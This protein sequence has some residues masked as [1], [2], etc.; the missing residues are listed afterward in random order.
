MGLHVHFSAIIYIAVI[1]C[2][3]AKVGAIPRG[4]SSDEYCASC[5]TVAKHLDR[6]VQNPNRKH[7]ETQI[8]LSLNHICD[9][10][11]YQDAQD[12]AILIEEACRYMIDHHREDIED[13]LLKYYRNKIENGKSASHLH[14]VQNV[15]G[16]IGA[17]RD[18]PKMKPE[19]DDHKHG[20]I[21][22]DEETE[23]VKIIP[24][25]KVKI[26]G[27]RKN[28]SATPAK[29]LHTVRKLHDEL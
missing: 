29:L 19:A 17:C 18:R 8:A 9:S 1:I 12:H 21:Y 5:Q 4:I 2:T 11:L 28:V 26:A 22:I 23:E 20:F 24:G 14:A 13:I 15:C 7:L 3:I 16:K 25:P 6:I 27:A 10:T